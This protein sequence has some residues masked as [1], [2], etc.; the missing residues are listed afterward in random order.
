MDWGEGDEN[1]FTY[2]VRLA[3]ALGS[4]ALG[5]GD[6]CRFD[7]LAG[8]PG[9]SSFG[10]ARG[11]HQ[12]LRLLNHLGTLSAGGQTVLDTDL[13][14]FAYSRR[15]PGLVVL[16]SDLLDPAGFREGLNRLLGWGHQV[17]VIQI[18]APD[19]LDPQI[20]GDLRLIDQE[21]GTSQEVS[22]DT[23][24]LAGYR[25]QL[26]TWLK[27]IESFC[28]GRGV[29]YARAST[30]SPWDRFVLRELRAEGVVK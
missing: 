12:T 7:L 27:E 19:E 4:I 24:V 26:E 25:R 28:H 22:L 16:I 30:G 14:R 17:V 29:G 21:F 11:A 2:G 15:R 6:P 13:S 5:G 3:A 8:D 23:V 1:K 9:G 20:T 18:L 10:P